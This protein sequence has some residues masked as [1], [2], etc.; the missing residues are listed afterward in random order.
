MKI[1]NH[2]QEIQKE[3][4]ALK[5][6]GQKVSL[7]PT[8][9]NLHAG[10][11]SLFDIAKKHSD[12]L[13]GSLFVNPIQFAPNEDLNRYPRTF[14]EDIRKLESLGV[15]FLFA[16][17]NNVIYP[18]GTKVN[19]SVK[20]NRLTQKLCGK[21]RPNHFEGVTTIVNMLFNIIQPDISVFGKKDYQQY[22]IIQAM[23]KDLFMP[24]ELIGA[25]IV[26]ETNGLAMSSRNKFLTDNQLTRASQLRKTLL[27]TVERIKNG[28]RQFDKIRQDS[29]Q[30]LTELDFKIDYFE[31][32]CAANLEKATLKDKN[33]LI[34]CAANLGQPRL[35][36]NIELTLDNS[37][38]I[39]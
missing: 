21:S 20:A 34:A 17:S 38:A 3:I 4:I 18:M 10:H 29:I 31:I 26:R 36:D 23:V 7:V 8:M 16:P 15:N 35:L 11:L 6:K 37:T 25:E 22:L 1:I 33:L 32:C 2:P 30:R 39:D 19:T 24:I 5:K 9:G 13:V 12:V 14:Q 27:R 28:E